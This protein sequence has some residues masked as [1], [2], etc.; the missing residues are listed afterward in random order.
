MTANPKKNSLPSLTQR[1]HQTY[2]T[3]PGG[4][5]KVADTVLKSP[6]DLAIWTASE[7]AAL[8][9]V[10]NATVTRLFRRLGYSN[11]DEARQASRRL[12]AQGS[13]LSLYE[14]QST[15]PDHIGFLSDL[16]RQEMA[17]VEAALA[18][19]DPIS[20]TEISARLASADCV[21]LAGFRNSRILAEYAAATLGQ[22]RN[23]V[24]LVGDPSQTL[25]E[26]IAGLGAGDIAVIIGLRRRPA[27]FSRFVKE[28]AATGAD[29]LLIADNSI[30]EAPMHATWSI[31]CAVETPHLIDSY[32]GA[33]AVIRALLLGVVN[34]LGEEGRQRLITLEKLHEN[35]SELE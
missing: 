18:A 34:C 9:G 28:V 21:R 1:L 32:V 29:I 4:E 27:F 2:S 24:V 33:M 13:P 23:D 31:T 12:R 30:R 26:S 20:V 25:A 8:T 7:L 6:G 15:S 11:Y 14:H 19:L 10:S 16:A 22:F 5:K 17:L 35:L 3:M